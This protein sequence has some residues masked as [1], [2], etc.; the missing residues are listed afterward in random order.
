MT[1]EEIDA[2]YKTGVRQFMNEEFKK[3]E[4]TFQKV[5]KADPGNAKAKDYLAKTRARLKLIK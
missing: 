2:L 1:A 4:A 5:I 3:A